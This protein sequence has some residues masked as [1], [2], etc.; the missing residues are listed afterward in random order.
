MAVHGYRGPPQSREKA[1]EGA[2]PPPVCLQRPS[3]KG[4]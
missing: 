4:A 1:W 2:P 3:T